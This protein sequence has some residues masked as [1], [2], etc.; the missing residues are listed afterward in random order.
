MKQYVFSQTDCRLLGRTFTDDQGLWLDWSMSGVWFRFRGTGAVF[1]FA[2][3]APGYIPQVGLEADGEGCGMHPIREDNLDIRT[4]PLTEGEHTVRLLKLTE[5]TV[6]MPLL[7]KAITL[8]GS[9]MW[10]PPPKLPSRRI[11]FIGDSIT[12]GFGTLSDKPSDPFTTE[13]EDPTKTYACRIARYFHAD[14]RFISMSGRGLL[15]DC[16][17][18]AFRPVP[19]WVDFTAFCHPEPWDYTRWQADIVVIN[20]GTNDVAGGTP[21]LEFE[22]AAKAFLKRIRDHYPKAWLL[23][24]HGMMNTE[25]TDPIRRA[26]DAVRSEGDSRAACFFTEPV[27]L[28]P[29]EM[30]ACGHPNACGHARFARELIPVIAAAAGWTAENT[31]EPGGE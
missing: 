7:L 2:L 21:G 3:P 14:A 22:E 25:M 23:W 16:A 13:T 11:E 20:V 6:G 15:R 5:A 26:V 8:E 17:G 18:A 31:D 4:P 30:G 24:V 12:C 10:L 29:E 28:H 27:R 19:E 9:G 1:H